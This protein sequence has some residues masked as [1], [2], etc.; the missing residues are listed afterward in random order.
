MFAPDKPWR[1]EIRY[2]TSDNSQW[3][4]I[5]AMWHQNLGVEASLVNEDWKVIL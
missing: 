1:V 3:I 5:E 4:A 2:D